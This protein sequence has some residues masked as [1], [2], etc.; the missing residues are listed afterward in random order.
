M[1]RIVR[2]IH[3]GNSARETVLETSP[4]GGRSRQPQFRSCCKL[5]RGLCSGACRK[6]QMEALLNRRPVSGTDHSVS[7]KILLV[8]GSGSQPMKPHVE[9][10][11]THRK[12]DFG[13]R[14]Q[15]RLISRGL[16]GLY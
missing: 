8:V 16:S 15:V 10:L 2:G 4:A 7:P 6:S 5:H 9:L 12:E 14:R 13:L 1:I 11:R 3:L